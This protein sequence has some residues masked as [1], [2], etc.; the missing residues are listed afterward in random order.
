M[1]YPCK[2]CNQ[3]KPESEVTTHFTPL[4]HTVERMRFKRCLKCE[5]KA[6]QRYYKNRKKGRA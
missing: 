1:K 3:M 5:A 2:S 4:G 6:K